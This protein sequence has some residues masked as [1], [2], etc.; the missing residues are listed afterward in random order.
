MN[1]PKQ[2]HKHSIALFVGIGCGLGIIIGAIAAYI[3]TTDDD[4]V[5]A[6]G[7]YSSLG[8]MAVLQ[9]RQ[10]TFINFQPLRE[11]LQNNYAE[12]DDY[13][14]SIY[15][16]YLPTGA[17][18]NIKKDAR[19]WPASLIK[20]PVGMAVMKKVERG[21]WKLSNELVILDE[22]KDKEFGELFRK[23]TGTT[24]TIERLLKEA[25]ARSDN[26]AHFTL[27][28]NLDSSELEEVFAHL[29]FDEILETL[30]RSPSGAEIDNRMTARSFSIFFRSLYNATYLSPEY[31]Q[32]F[33]NILLNSPREYLALGLP[34]DVP[35]AHKTGIRTDDRAWTDSG[36]VYLPRRPYLL[37]VMIQEKPGASDPAFSPE[38]IFSM[39]SKEIYDYVVNLR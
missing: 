6:L 29:G 14:V 4:I 31:S 26:T 24:I 12:R 19:I 17:H 18:I 28:R 2:P 8:P 25:L 21:D 35:F 10:D 7:R 33:L 37:T 5:A 9:D 3:F 22:D 15:F 23:P 30:K 34:K 38:T 36:I 27:L 1:K 32:R 13:L 20:I 11:S 16:E 39:I